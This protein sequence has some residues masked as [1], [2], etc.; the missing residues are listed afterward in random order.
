MSKNESERKVHIAFDPDTQQRLQPDM[1]TLFLQELSAIVNPL[2]E[3][4]FIWFIYH[5]SPQNLPKISSKD[6]TSIVFYDPEF[7]DPE[8]LEGYPHHTCEYHT[9]QAENHNF[10]TIAQALFGILSRSFSLRGSNG[11]HS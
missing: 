2:Q 8:N 5:D 9:V 7:S 6:E 10:R 3:G 4:V 1:T 11:H